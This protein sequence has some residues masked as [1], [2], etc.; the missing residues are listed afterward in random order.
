[1]HLYVRL[2]TEYVVQLLTVWE[3]MVLS[4]SKAAG[5]S[6]W[7]SLANDVIKCAL[8]AADV[9][10]HLEPVSLSRDDGKRPDGLSLVPWKAGRCLVWDF[11]GPDMFAASHLNRTVT[12]AG[13]VAT[14]AEEKKKQKYCN[15][16]ATYC[17]IP[18]AVESARAFGQDA[19]EFLQELG[20][21]IAAGDSRA[22][23]FLFQRLS[24]AV[25]RGNAACVLGAC[26]VLTAA[27]TIFYC[28]ITV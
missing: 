23:E 1:M 5:R 20:R 24:V 22:T 16:S 13:A 14:E 6:S 25:Q 9:P 4:C 12:C 3:L 18:L 17:F 8:S 11:T 26:T 10:C 27:V 2:S 28:L 15:L 19:T 21:R 7:H